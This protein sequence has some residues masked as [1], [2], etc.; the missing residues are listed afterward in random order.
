MVENIM[1]FK[2][3]VDSLIDNISYG[4]LTMISAYPKYWIRAD[5]VL[6]VTDRKT[7]QENLEKIYSLNTTLSDRFSRKT[8]FD[9]T[10]NQIIN[11]KISGNEFDGNEKNF[12]KDLYNIKPR[13]FNVTAP[14]SGVRLD[15]EERKYKLSSFEFGYLEDLKFPI[16][17][18]N[19]MFIRTTIDHI[20]DKSLAMEKAE[21]IFKDFINLLV[22]FSGK[23]DHS[24]FITTGL[25][26]KP[27]MSHEQMYVSTSS[28]QLADEKDNLENSTINNKLI[29]KIPVNN[30]FFS[31]NETFQLLWDFY[32]RRHSGKKLTDIE[33]RLLNS[34]IALGESALTAGSKNSIIYTCISLETLFSY[35]E[36]SLFQKSIGEKLADIFVY[37]VAKDK[38]TRINTAKLIKKV[39][40][41]RSAI[42]HGGTKNLSQENLVVNFLMRAA[43][44]EILLG[45]RFS[46][47]KTI[48]QIYDQLKMAQNSY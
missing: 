13:T 38:E 5:K 34:A 28:Y 46:G 25:P 33:G 26:L 7:Y 4:D 41:L 12:F 47:V 3:I 32:E 15:N 45:Q 27:S 22:F 31:Q 44:A 16:S 40:S 24:I 35:D 2:S 11:I 29:E 20:Y 48:A 36:G 43:I 21:N 6:Y 17:N 30:K 39:Y 19:G 9:F 14:I 42:V 8:F 10:E 37:V 23:Q 1:E 18:E